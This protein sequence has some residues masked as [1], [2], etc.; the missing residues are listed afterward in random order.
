MCPVRL[1]ECPVC[2]VC[3][4]SRKTVLSTL[5][6]GVNGTNPAYAD[7]VGSNAGFSEPQLVAVD[8]SGN[9]YVGDAGN[10]R[11][12]K[13]TPTGVVTTFAGSGVPTFADGQGTQS[14]FNYPVGVSI[15]PSGN[16]V[17]TDHNNY[18]IRTVTPTGVVMTLAGSAQGWQDGTGSSASFF[19]P[20]PVAT[21]SSG[22]MVI[23]EYRN[24][25][26]RKVSPAGVVTSLAGGVSGTT[27]A[28]ADAIGS[29]AGFNL[30]HGCALDC[31][32][33]NIYVADGVNQRI[34][35]VLPNGGASIVSVRWQCVS[36]LYP[37]HY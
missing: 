17:V 33:G 8:A 2:I 24:Q 19:G 16:L 34:R 29:L 26:I 36:L 30:P 13:V 18:R 9:T 28:F 10:H 12:R 15:S 35:K 20:V 25:R 21:D 4:L 27:G 23:G 31:V 22:N 32:S 1:A 11:I 3:L 5:A 37:K 14:S 6:G 7:G